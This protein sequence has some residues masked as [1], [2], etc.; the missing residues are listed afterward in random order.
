MFRI[1][2]INKNKTLYNAKALLQEYTQATSKELPVYQ[3]KGAT[4]PAHNKIFEVEVFYQDKLLGSGSGKSKK[5]A[6]QNAAL[7]AC[8][9]VNLI[10][11][12][13]DNE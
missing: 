1:I 10:E 7:S 4:G 8:K 2:E 13:E 9:K 6:Q 5:E 12:E 3:L 11:G